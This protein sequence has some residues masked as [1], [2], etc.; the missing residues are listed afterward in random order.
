MKYSPPNPS[1]RHRYNTFI[2]KAGTEITPMGVLSVFY[3][4][5]DNKTNTF[6]EVISL[7]PQ[8]LKNPPGAETSQSS[9]TELGR[10]TPQGNTAPVIQPRY[11]MNCRHETA[12]PIV[13]FG[14]RSE[15]LPET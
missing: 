4:L 13:E 5:S 11:F 3:H 8:A 15:A 6:E 7:A 10:S 1:E 14:M 12:L 2:A 9:F